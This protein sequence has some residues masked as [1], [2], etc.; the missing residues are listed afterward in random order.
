MY[1]NKQGYELRSYLLSMA[2]FGVFCQ[3]SFIQLMRFGIVIAKFFTLEQFTENLLSQA[4]NCQTMCLIGKFWFDQLLFTSIILCTI[5][6]DILNCT[7]LRQRLTHFNSAQNLGNGSIFGVS[8]F[9][10]P[11]SNCIFSKFFGA[12]IDICKFRGHFEQVF[13]RN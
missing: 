11:I 9:G 2:I 6:L 8:I 10:V 5:R 7:V 3:A 4:Q 13:S 1:R 12:K